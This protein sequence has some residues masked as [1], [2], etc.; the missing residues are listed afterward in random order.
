MVELV[1]NKSTTQQEREKMITKKEKKEFVR[2]ML[3]TNRTWALKAM[4]LVYSYQTKSEQSF[5]Q[6]VEHNGRGFSQ[7]HASLMTSFVNGFRKFDRL[8]DNQMQVLFKIMPRYWKQ[9]LEASDAQKL[10]SLMQKGA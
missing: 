3:S 6:T 5:G 4:L 2:K 7:I 1:H 8:T 9:V 10:E